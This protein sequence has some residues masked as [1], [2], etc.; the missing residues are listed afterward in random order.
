MAQQRQQG[1]QF[2][3]PDSR[4]RNNT[5]DVVHAQVLKVTPLDESLFDGFPSMRALTYTSSIPMIV[6]LLTKHDFQ[7]FECIFGHEGILSREAAEILAFQTATSN[8]LSQGF[9]AVEGIPEDRINVIYDRVASGSLSFYVIKDAIAHAKIYLLENQETGDN[10][11]ITGSANLSET[12]FSGRQ[13]ETLTVFDND[14]KAWSHY[15]R[16][17]EDVREL[18]TNR[19]E[20]RKK[21]IG[22]EQIQIE[23]TPA[24]KDAESSGNKGITLY[25][26]AEQGTEKE[27]S[28]RTLRTTVDRLKPIFQRA[29]T[30]LRPD[31]NGNLTITPPKARQMAAAVTSRR[32]EEIQ[33]V[34]LTREGD[35]FTLSGA[36]MP[37]EWDPN[38]VKSDVN[39]LLEFFRN[40]EQGFKGDVPRL[41]K[42]YFTFMCWL[43]FSPLMCDIRNAAISRNNFS[44]D[45]PL[46]AV[47]YGSSNCGKTILSETLMT[48][49]FSKSQ[50]VDVSDFTPSK[51]R[52]FQ[53]LYKRH[54]I[55][56]DDVDRERFRRHAPEIIKNEYI[57]LPEYPCV[58][59]SMN[60]ETRNFPPEIIKRSL[61]IYTRTSLPGNLPAEQ[62]RLQRAAARIKENLTPHLYR[63]FLSEATDAVNNL[64]ESPDDSYDALELAST[65]ICRIFSENLPP[66]QTL[67]QWCQKMTLEEY[68]M[69]AFDRPR[70]QLTELLHRDKYSRDPKVPEGCWRVSGNQIIVSA[71]TMGANR[72]K[73]D[74]PDWIIDDTATIAGRITLDKKRAEDFLSQTLNPPSRLA[75][76]FRK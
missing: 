40:Y 70:A 59:L 62:R 48:S 66:G 12:A 21:P 72:I 49:M 68:K 36:P 16:Q 76:I 69:R 33:Q 22:V 44:F 71:P 52:N 15:N 10:R 1:F 74:I 61:M 55:V 13:A 5:L 8:A 4:T 45:Q 46:F 43:Y 20:L 19:L 47:L 37:L 67:P 60:A 64:I 30:D 28:I 26:P 23:E 73:E 38:R 24:L 50:A 34:S 56:F 18:S 27:F 25:M 41:Q 17:Y 63:L 54:P 35:K 6:S 32:S 29:T 11:V 31:K 75:S 39:N 3:D 53:G 2:D 58:A 7:S 57:Y 51:L 65:I 9:T 14:T 42:D